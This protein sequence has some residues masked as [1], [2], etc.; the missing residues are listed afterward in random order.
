MNCEFSPIFVIGSA[1]SGTT[2]TA[3]LIF[4]HPR[5]FEYRAE[6]L[7]LSVCKL[8]YGNIFRDSVKLSIFLEDWFKSRQ[9]KESKLDR[10]EFIQIVETSSNYEELLINFL[11]KMCK[12]SGSA[13]IVDS[14]PAHGL[15]ISNIVEEC[16]SAKFINI[17]RDPRSV[18]V[19]QSKLG[20]TNP[21][22]P[23]KSRKSRLHYCVVQ[24][25]DLLE[26]VENEIVKG[27]PICM[28]RYEDLINNTDATIQSIASHLSMD[29]KD[30]DASIISTGSDS[31]SAFGE[32]SNKRE[33]NNPLNRWKTLD[34]QTAIEITYGCGKLLKKYGYLREPTPFQ[35]IPHIRY[36]YFK[37][38][39]KTKRLLVR[40]PYFGKFI[41]SSLELLR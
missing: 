20:W 26:R 7:M 41:S 23:F 25:K 12:N 6:T 21:P 17:I 30:L 4:S 1:R 38:H 27:S 39:V 9:F 40:L 31:N 8:K 15:F 3:R 10:T 36:L 28:I 19:S 2:L 32:I 37:A 33:L 11:S 22:F 18:A 5:C 24:W 29:Q 13:Y 14:T 16:R 34:E 35:P